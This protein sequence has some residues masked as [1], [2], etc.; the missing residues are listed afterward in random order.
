MNLVG[1]R[2][3]QPGK[4]NGEAPPGA[5]AA[6]APASLAPGMKYRPPSRWVISWVSRSAAPTSVWTGTR[7]RASISIATSRTP[8]HQ[9]RRSSKSVTEPGAPI[10]AGPQRSRPEQQEAIDELRAAREAEQPEPVAR[11]A[12][13]LLH[14]GDHVE[15][16][17]V[18]ADA[19]FAE[20]LVAVGIA[21]AVDADREQ[22]TEDQRIVVLAEVLKMI[23]E[24][25]EGARA[26][27]DDDQQ[28]GPD[29]AGP[30]ARRHV[31]AVREPGDRGARHRPPCARCR[32]GQASRLPA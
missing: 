27:M 14:L 8:T 13:A 15:K 5:A 21:V 1:H 18:V 20:I 28:L 30:V 22:R 10:E 2:H 23:A 6:R 25:H 17:V 12:P 4:A 16:D 31:E 29:A 26:A 19:G 24:L 32:R 9:S 11:E 3:A 7:L